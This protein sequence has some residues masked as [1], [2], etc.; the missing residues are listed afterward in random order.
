M[1]DK[2]YCCSTCGKTYRNDKSLKSHLVHCQSQNEIIKEMRTQLEELK[3]VVVTL[4]GITAH[5]VPPCVNTSIK[6]SE[7]IQKQKPTHAFGHEN[8]T[9]L[10]TPVAS[11]Y[12]V[13]LVQNN[14][15]LVDAFRSVIRKLYRDPAHKENC[16]VL[17]QD[18]AFQL[19]NGSG[20]KRTENKMGVVKKAR[21]RVNNILQHFITTDSEEFIKAVGSPEQLE[22]LDNF[23]YRIDTCDEYPEFEQEINDLVLDELMS[24]G[25]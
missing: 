25:V 2:P 11:C 21:Q 13:D 9:H 15:D 23:T 10:V 3:D 8:Y 14:S 1:S 18:D 24:N 12:I 4:V 19:Y 17:F 6:K 22:Q 7:K 16:T 20:W 5:L